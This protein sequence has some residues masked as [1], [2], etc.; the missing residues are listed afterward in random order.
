MHVLHD[1]SVL[2]RKTSF[3]AGMAKKS[4]AHEKARP[5]EPSRTKKRPSHMQF[6][7]R[8][9]FQQSFCTASWPK[10]SRSFVSG[11]VAPQ[12]GASVCV[13]HI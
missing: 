5:E 11:T 13:A 12:V 9:S 2:A 3:R 1:G 7:M 10:K 8:P 6:S 4:K